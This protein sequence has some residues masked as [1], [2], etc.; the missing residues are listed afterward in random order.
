MKWFCFLGEDLGGGDWHEPDHWWWVL[1]EPFWV[2]L[3]GHVLWVL[4]LL[5]SAYC[6]IKVFR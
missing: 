3:I 6:T 5:L 4:L 2:K 1:L